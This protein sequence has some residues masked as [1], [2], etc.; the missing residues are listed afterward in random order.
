MEQFERA[1]MPPDLHMIVSDQWQRRG[2]E[3]TGE[4]LHWVCCV[5]RELEKVELVPRKQ[6]SHIFF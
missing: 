4:Q 5:D 3:T 6:H 2:G 1:T